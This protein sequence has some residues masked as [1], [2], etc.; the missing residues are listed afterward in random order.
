[1][2]LFDAREN[3]FPPKGNVHNRIHPLENRFVGH[4]VAK[5]ADKGLVCQIKGRHIQM[6]FHKR[7]FLILAA[8]ASFSECTEG[9]YCIVVWPF[10]L[11]FL[12]TFLGFFLLVVLRSF[13]VPFA[14]LHD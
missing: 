8:P 12:G 2:S 10:F 6:P 14:Q 11:E 7:Y 4:T 5:V 1:V 13:L 9:C 3:V